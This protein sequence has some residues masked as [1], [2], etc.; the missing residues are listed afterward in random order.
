MSRFVGRSRGWI[1]VVL[2]AALVLPI[3][4]WAVDE[5]AFRTSGEAV[6]DELGDAAAVTDAL[7]LVRSVGCDGQAS[8]GSA[9][10]LDLDGEAIVLTNR[11]VVADARSVSVRPLSGGAFEPV[12]GFETA[13]DADV[14]VLDLGEAAPIPAALPR[15]TAV[16]EGTEVRTV[17][18]PSGRPS[19]GT[20]TVVAVDAARLVI[21]VPVSGGASGS[22]VLDDDGR[23]VGQI[24]GT[25]VGG[26]AVATPIERV[27]GSL[28]DTI[29][30]AP[31]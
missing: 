13:A 9:F 14:A 11:H 8:T 3:G 17:G 29:A 19:T 6:T 12:A 16:G 21:E 30:A 24:F 15:G 1:A 27:V 25:A 18:F 10:V 23:V 7:L 28:A 22:P 4:R 26:E 2:V 20:G 31:C 5:F